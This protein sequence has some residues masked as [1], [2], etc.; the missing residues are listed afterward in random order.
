MSLTLRSLHCH[1]RAVR[2]PA[3]ALGDMHRKRL[4]SW[5][6]AAFLLLPVE[7]SAA[8]CAFG[9]APAGKGMKASFIRLHLGCPQIT[10][11]PAPN[12]QTAEGVP[13]CAPPYPLPSPYTFEAGMK[14]SC[15][16]THR[17]KRVQPCWNGSSDAC[18]SSK[19]KVKCS[20]ILDP[21]DAPTNDPGFQLVATVRITADDPT[22]GDMTVFDLPIEF[23][24][25]TN[26][27]KLT[28]DAG[29]ELLPP[30]FGP[31]AATSCVQIQFLRILIEDPEGRNFAVAGVGTLGPP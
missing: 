2:A 11:F 28:L 15:T 24:L 3:R 8:Q 31:L 16:L 18:P 7:E 4:G 5:A 6:V 14:S 10:P 12:S 23:P 20:G 26:K 21:D 22:S 27:G 13:S 25:A 30:I 9:G 19:L 17:L 1:Y 29:P